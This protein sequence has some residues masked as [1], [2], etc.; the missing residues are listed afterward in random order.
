ML[1]YCSML[2]DRAGASIH[3]TVNNKIADQIR[4]KVSFK[5][6]SNRQA[7]FVC[8]FLASSCPCTLTW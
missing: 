1:C 6:L 5:G 2:A 7:V 8:F 3:L 4:A